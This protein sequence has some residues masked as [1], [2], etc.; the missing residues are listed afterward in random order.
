MSTG[1]ASAMA[2]RRPAERSQAGAWLV[3]LLRRREALQN[4]LGFCAAMFIVLAAASVISD[5][6]VGGREVSYQALPAGDRN[7]VNQSH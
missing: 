3:H 4:W 7:A 2:G 6:P 5:E 1:L